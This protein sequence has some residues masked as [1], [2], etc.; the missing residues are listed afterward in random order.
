MTEW[1]GKMMEW[2]EDDGLGGKMTEWGEDD[3][4]GGR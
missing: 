2:G 3:G 1:G 4:R